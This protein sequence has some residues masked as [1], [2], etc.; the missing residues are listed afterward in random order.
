MGNL[1][2]YVRKSLS[3]GK[4]AVLFTT[5]VVLL[6]LGGIYREVRS[7]GERV[8]NRILP[9]QAGVSGAD[10]VGPQKSD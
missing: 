5:Y 8:A 4:L 7:L 1:L 9:E 6:S 10:A 2:Q 3:L